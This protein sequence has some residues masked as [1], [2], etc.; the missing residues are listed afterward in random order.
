MKQNNLR[1]YRRR[2]VTRKSGFHTCDE[3]TGSECIIVNAEKFM[4]SDNKE[5]FIFKRD[6]LQLVNLFKSNLGILC[7]GGYLWC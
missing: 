2:N 1:T 7:F 5:V 6:N 3:T 4:S